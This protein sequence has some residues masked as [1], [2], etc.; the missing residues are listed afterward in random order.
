VLTRPGGPP[1]SYL[2]Y[3]VNLANGQITL[4]ERVGPSATPFGFDG[5]FAVLPEPATG[6]LGALGLATGVLAARRRRV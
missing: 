6:L 2:L 5:G 1:G 3:H 4:G